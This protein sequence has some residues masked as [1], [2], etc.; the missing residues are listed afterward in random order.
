[1]Q[2]LNK[3]VP[4]T[5]NTERSGSFKVVQETESDINILRDISKKKRWDSV[6]EQKSYH[7]DRIEEGCTELFEL[8]G[9]GLYLVCR[10]STPME[11]PDS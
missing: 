2:H 4:N 5:P 10:F 11:P 7:I 9:L 3:L 1:L 8:C 6:Q